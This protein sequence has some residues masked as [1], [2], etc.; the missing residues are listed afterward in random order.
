MRQLHSTVLASNTRP[1]SHCWNWGCERGD[2]KS[3]SNCVAMA[4]TLPP[5]GVDRRSSSSTGWCSIDFA[6]L[7]P[8]NCD[9]AQAYQIH[10]GRL[11]S[12]APSTGQSSTDTI[13]SSESEPAVPDAMAGPRFSPSVFRGMSRVKKWYC[14]HPVRP[15]RRLG[16]TDAKKR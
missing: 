9:H 8:T 6:A 10:L 5:A 7:D 4:T 13:V 11:V 3:R 2:S 15:L 14:A 1:N 16:A 12:T